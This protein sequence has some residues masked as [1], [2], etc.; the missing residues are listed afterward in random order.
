MQHNSQSTINRIPDGVLLSETDQ[1]QSDSQYK[2]TPEVVLSNKPKY[3]NG[4][5]ASIGERDIDAV[6]KLDADDTTTDN[7]AEP[8]VQKKVI[9]LSINNGNI[10]DDK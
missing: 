4:D 9:P 3:Q 6:D 10:V 7:A 8:T 5:M 2:Y 1:V